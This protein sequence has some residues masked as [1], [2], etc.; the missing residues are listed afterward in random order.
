MK[1]AEAFF[2]LHKLDES[3]KWLTRRAESRILIAINRSLLINLPTKQAVV[4]RG[5]VMSFIAEGRPPAFS[6]DELF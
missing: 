5:V 4:E 2:E 6:E 1:P 3:Y